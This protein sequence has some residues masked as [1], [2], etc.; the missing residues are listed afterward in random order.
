MALDLHKVRI[1]QALKP[2][3]E[4]YWGAPLGRGRYLGL[5]KIDEQR[6]TWIARLRTDAGT[7][8]YRSLGYL[9]DDY[10]YEEAKVDAVSWFKSVEAGVTEGPITIEQACKDYV[11]DRE[12]QKG[13][14]TARDAEARFERTV[15]GTLF[16]RMRLDQLRTP[17]LRKWREGLELGKS[18]SNRTLTSLKAALNLAVSNRKVSADRR[19]EWGEVK[20]HKAAGERRQL[21]LDVTQRRALLAAASGA[22]KDLMTAAATTGARAGEL[23]NAPRSAFDARTGSMTFKGKT[24]SRTVPLSPAAITLF[25]RLAKEKLPEAPLLVRDDGKPWAHSDWDQLVRAAATKAELPTG[26]CLYTL[27][28]SFITQTITDGMTTLDVARLTGTSVMM[29]EKHYGHLVASAA[30]KRLKKVSLI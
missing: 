16:G 20:P 9:A 15:Y 13:K 21:F 8:T 10:D 30:A 2:R 22:I 3:R 12:T 5:R 1:R 27:R 6:A 19:I 4:P 14:G 11:T 17:H 29:I 28:H 7:Q 26:T 18:S 25:K 24:G 23:V